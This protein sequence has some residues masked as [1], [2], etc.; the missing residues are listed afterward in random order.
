M[1][2]GIMAGGIAAGTPPGDLADFFSELGGT[3]GFYSHATWPAG[4]VDSQG[5]TRLFYEAWTGSRRMMRTMRYDQSGGDIAAQRGISIG[6]LTNDDHGVPAGCED[7]AGYLFA[8]GN[9]H[10]TDLYCYSSTVPITTDADPVFRFRNA[11]VGSYS[12]PHPVVVGGTIYLFCRKFIGSGNY[13][14]G[15]FKTTSI[16]AGVPTWSAF[17]EI[18]TFNGG[19][20]ARVYMGNS[21]LVGTD[22]HFVATN[23]DSTDT[24]R[25][26][27][28]YFKMKTASSDAIDNFDGTT[29]TA[30]GSWPIHLT[31]ANSN[32]RI[33]DSGS[34]RTDIPYLAFDSSGNP[35]IT[36]A[37]GTGTT[38]SFKHIMHD[39]SA[40]TSA[41]TIA[42]ITG[43]AGIGFVG[44]CAIIPRA[45]GVVDFHYPDN[46]GGVIRGEA[47]NW[48]T[49]SRDA[50]GALGPVSSVLNYGTQPIG[51]MFGPLNAGADIRVF[52]SEIADTSNDADAGDL[53]IYAY[54]DSGLV[55]PDPVILDSATTAI[56][57]AFSTDPGTARKLTVNDLV[58]R[59]KAY[60][61]WSKLD[62]LYLMAAHESAAALINW[63]NPGTYD[64]TIGG[65]APTF[66]ADS[67]YSTDGVDDFLSTNFNPATAGGNFAQN[68]AS[69]GIWS[70]TSGQSNS[71]KAGWFDGTDGI[72][73]NPRN[74]S[75]TGRMQ[76][77]I[78]QAVVLESAD[79][80]SDG[81]GLYVANRSASG[82]VQ[83]YR[84]GSSLFTGTNAS[85]ALNS[86]NIRLGSVTAAAFGALG[87]RAAFIGSSLNATEQ[88]DLYGSVREY[89]QQVGAVS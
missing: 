49:R 16:T 67:G 46:S 69:F 81:T 24:A 38:F 27:V 28:Y 43:T 71:S 59:L 89:L 37:D 20:G 58:L 55:G 19:S 7:S 61:I 75:A 57:S 86:A 32:Y 84:N 78:N 14:L 2:H 88:A 18:L 15:Y 21:Y 17:V 25:K 56:V 40:W 70:A 74:S 60:G 51:R 6:I 82:A 26:G 35:H 77:R 80:V 33:V 87:F 34:N 65:G 79:V 23:A 1:I 53:R 22:I 72:T 52:A 64:L 68:S 4:F 76:I 48:K 11:F 73:L 54:G 30:S 3:Q 44:T 42:S 85:T 66:T 39:G 10:N 47:G 50:G 9:S 8:F 63:K 41:L 45:S 13:T 31:N 62:A 5:D 29:T 12:Y 83:G 36:Y